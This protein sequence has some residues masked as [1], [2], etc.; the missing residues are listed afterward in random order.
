MPG[1][2]I[3]SRYEILEELGTGGMGKVFKALD[4]ELGEEIALKSLHSDLMR[5]TEARERFLR[6]IKL[7]RKITHPNV[8]RVHDIGRWEDHEFLTMEYLD[9]ETM[10]DH[11]KHRG[12]YAVPAGVHMAAQICDGLEQAHRHKIVHRDLKPQNIVVTADG[13]PKILDFGI[14]RAGGEGKDLTA[15]G[16]LIGS[17]KYM[18]P[19]QILGK[20]MDVRSDLYSL[21]IVFYYMF[22]G[23]EPF[24]GETV[25]AIVMR[26]VEKAP[27]PLA[28][29]VPQFPAWLDEVIA[30][31]LRK[32]P[33]ERYA[34]AASLRAAFEE[35]LK[36]HEGQPGAR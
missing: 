8:V 29:F 6:E 27:P 35:G 2:V 34:S 12:P 30:K 17:P 25:E 33:A 16:Q 26:Q 3:S 36:R 18:S 32:N 23:R 22:S 5:D 11:V 1:V 21:G 9:A 24:E 10:F 7:L 15:T 4:R 19:E 31:T 20:A 28:S 13:T 14:A